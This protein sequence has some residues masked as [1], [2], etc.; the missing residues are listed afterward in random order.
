M[1]LDIVLPQALHSVLSFGFSV[2]SP[3]VTSALT[4]LTPKWLLLLLRLRNASFLF[5][6]P[7]GVAMLLLKPKIIR[8]LAFAVVLV[9]VGLISLVGVAFPVISFGDRVFLIFSVFL[10]L[11]FLLPFVVLSMK[12]V[13]F[14]KLGAI[15]IVVIFMLTFALGLWGAS[16]APVYLYSRDSSSSA[17]GEH[18]LSWPAVSMFMRFLGGKSCVLTNEIYVTSIALPVTD[19]PSVNY[20]GN[21]VT[22]QGCLT[23]LFRGV[24]SFNGSYIGE[25]IYSQPGFQYKSFEVLLDHSNSVFSADNVKVYEMAM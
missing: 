11:I 1:A 13:N 3:A 6:L 17:F 15:A 24:N 16:Y 12:Y 22:A 2:P 4:N 20:I 19:W 7:A 14:A 21:T 10:G 5:L 25:P 9:L 18:P 8:K 23:I